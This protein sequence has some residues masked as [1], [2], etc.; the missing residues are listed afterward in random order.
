MRNLTITVATIILTMGSA[1]ADQTAHKSV[2]S[3][4]Q[5]STA[6]QKA[7]SPKSADQKTAD[8]AKPDTKD[9][10]ASAQSAP[11]PNKYQSKGNWLTWPKMTGD[12]GGARTTL[13]EHGIELDLRLTQSY[14][15]VASGGKNTNFAYGGK[16]DY[17]LNIDGK[18]L[19]LWEGFFVTMHA[20]TQFGDS[21]LGDAG[22]FS[23]PNTV[24]LWPLP[25][26]HET[27]IT[28]LL[29][30]Q[31][32]S[33]NF[34]L[35]A[36]K[37]NVLDLWT[38]VYPRRGAFDGFMNTN[39]LVGGAAIP[40]FRFV[41][42]SVLGAGGLVLRDDGQLQG[43]VL[44]FDLNNSTTTTG[45]P[46]LFT[47]GGGVLGLWIFLLDIADKPGGLLLVFV[48]GTQT[49]I[50]YDKS[51]WGLDLRD[52]RLLVGK[53]TGPWT[54]AIFYDQ[55]LWENPDNKKQNV[56]FLTGWSVSSG[57][58]NFAKWSGSASVEATGLLPGREKD[59]AGVGSLYNQ[60]TSELKED[61]TF[62][63]GGLQDTWGTEVYY[64][65]EITPWMHLTP[66]LQVIQNQNKVDDPGVI[67]GFRAVIN[68]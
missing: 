46:E 18:K 2:P 67:V 25:N 61:F 42:L 37:I 40:W 41:N 63:G 4:N 48:G 14:Q 47:D 53:K 39:M 22:A 43:G 30:E 16:L 6:E 62:L 36:G 65:I 52:R 9:H 60:L 11:P 17:I 35:A 24:M 54:A 33:K 8:D 56:W 64:N 28:G 44:V 12:W 68:F 34:V 31:A 10:D 20:E 32:L 29:V 1:I 23:L 26:Q 45:I 55:V 66:N 58:P 59:K 50:S 21:I 57:N 51:D 3:P 49:Y 19:G 27:A 38:M 13:A 7:A 15:G 5:A